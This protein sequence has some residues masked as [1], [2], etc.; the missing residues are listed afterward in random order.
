M[1]ALTKANLV[2]FALLAAHTLDHAINQPSRDLPATGSIV[3]VAGFVVVAASAVLALRRSSSAPASAV[4][5]GVTT[6]IGFL[7]IH[8]LPAWSEPISDPY[9]D[10]SANALSWVLLIAPLGA[11]IA[12]AVIGMRMLARPAPGT[13]SSG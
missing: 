6:T 11:A 1:T 8:V 3:G 9:W 4:F 13:L 5:A 2:L 10:F 12:L 7:A